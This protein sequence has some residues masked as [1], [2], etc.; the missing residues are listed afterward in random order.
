M[1]VTA[2]YAHKNLRLCSKHFSDSCFMNVLQ[3]NSLVWDA[4][5]SLF[6]V[7]NPP[8]APSKRKV[9]A[10]Q[11]LPPPLKKRKTINQDEHEVSGMVYMII[12]FFYW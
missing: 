10:S 2:D 11:D 3:R 9:P 4:V 12:S 7:P 1:N 8:L 5:P 6:E